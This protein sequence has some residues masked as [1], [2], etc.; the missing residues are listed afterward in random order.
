[1]DTKI[2]K[3][4]TTSGKD[5]YYRVYLDKGKQYYYHRV[6]LTLEQTPS[7]EEYEIGCE[8]HIEEPT[9]EPTKN[10]S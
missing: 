4:K 9:K 7:I 2:I 5:F 8:E 3:V 10:D 6:F 1:M